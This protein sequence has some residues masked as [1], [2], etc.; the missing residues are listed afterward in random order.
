MGE[1]DSGTEKA[2]RENRLSQDIPVIWDKINL[3]FKV[4]L[5]PVGCFALFLASSQ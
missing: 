5:C 3:C 4:L 2:G 1:G